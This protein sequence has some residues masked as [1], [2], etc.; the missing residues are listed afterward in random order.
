MDHML[1]MGYLFVLGILINL[2]GVLMAV[3]VVYMNFSFSMCGFIVVNAVIV[4][5]LPNYLLFF[6]I[7][8][9]RS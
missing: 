5:F 2:I 7:V 1:S 4:I 3:P 9:F 6:L 8:F